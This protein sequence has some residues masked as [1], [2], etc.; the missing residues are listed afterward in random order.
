LPQAV[1]ASAVRETMRRDFF[2]TMFLCVD[3]DEVRDEKT[4]NA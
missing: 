2:M 3:D 1:K 4:H